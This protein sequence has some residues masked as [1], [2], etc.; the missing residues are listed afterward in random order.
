M[1]DKSDLDLTAQC[2]LT[3]YNSAKTLINGGLLNNVQSLIGN[4]N[5]CNGL[6]GNNQSDDLFGSDQNDLLTQNLLTSLSK[7]DQLDSSSAQSDAMY[8]TANSQRNAFRNDK[9]LNQNSS[10]SSSSDNKKVHRCTYDGC[11][12]VYGKA[13][14]QAPIP[15]RSSA[16]RPNLTAY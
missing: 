12:K 2:L 4:G 8:L 15:L 7:N 13:T 3:F 14:N 9:D 10:S 5:D 11:S 16:I 1:S 6:F